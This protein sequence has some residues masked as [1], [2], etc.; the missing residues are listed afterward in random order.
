MAKR[1]TKEAADEPVAAE[2]ELC[3]WCDQ[4][5]LPGDMYCAK[6][7]AQKAA[8]D[9]VRFPVNKPPGPNPQALE[10]ARRAGI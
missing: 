8:F 10:D 9:R 7:K 6:C 1:T 2:V 5:P 4:P 3:Y